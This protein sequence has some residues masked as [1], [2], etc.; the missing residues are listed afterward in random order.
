MD[1]SST[2]LAS[3]TSSENKK[4]VH[5]NEACHVHFIENA[6]D[7]YSPQELKDVY[8]TKRDMKRW[9]KMSEALAED[10]N[11]YSCEELWD[12]F[13]IRSKTQ[14][15]IRRQIRWATLQA[16][17]SFNESS[18]EEDVPGLVSDSEHSD[19]DDDTEYFRITEACSIVAKARAERIE[20]QVHNPKGITQ[21]Y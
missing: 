12:R 9:R 18:G 15:R 3:S 4:S 19:S 21:V 5:F 14:K 13:G 7:S 6:K 10:L 2:S 8:Y 1:P 11:F 16:V 17:H 20:E